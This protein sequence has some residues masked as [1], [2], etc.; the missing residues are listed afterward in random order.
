MTK[1][2]AVYARVSTNEQSVDLQVKELKNYIKQQGWE[3]FSIYEDKRTGTNA[4]RPQFKKMIEDAESGSFDT[5]ICWKLD[6]LFRSLKD[7]INTLNYFASKDISF[8]ALK[9]N[10]DLTTSSGRLM[11]HIIGAFAEFEA[12]I[13]RERVVS[14]LNAAKEK[15]VKLGRPKLRNDEL[16]HSLR[17]QGMTYKQIKDLTNYSEGT[18]ANSLKK[19]GV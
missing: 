11:M 15:G 17:D 19:K 4:N 2:V 12:S 9:D 13:I 1:K 10:I 3:I 8:I 7:L 16:I 5:V 18:I 14:G 6:R